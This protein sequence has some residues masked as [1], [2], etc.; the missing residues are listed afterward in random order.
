MDKCPVL[1][2]TFAYVLQASDA[3]SNQV[4]RPVSHGPASND[5]QFLPK[6]MET[7]LIDAKYNQKFA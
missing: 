2:S 1:L 4:I 7:C 6:T 5:T 3:G